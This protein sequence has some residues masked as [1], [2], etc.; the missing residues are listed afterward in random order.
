MY[1]LELFIIWRRE[2]DTTVKS[3]VLQTDFSLITVDRLLWYIICS[4]Q[5]DNNEVEPYDR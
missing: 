3:R 1:F 2:H 4:F 5:L